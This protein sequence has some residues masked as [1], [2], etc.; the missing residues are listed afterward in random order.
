MPTVFFDK[1]H[2]TLFTFPDVVLCRWDEVHYRDKRYLV[3]NKTFN[4]DSKCYEMT[5]CDV[6]GDYAKEQEQLLR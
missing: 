1:Q 6:D 5:L 2:N 4:A 3:I